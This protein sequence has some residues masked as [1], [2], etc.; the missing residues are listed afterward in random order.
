[1]IRLA[2]VGTGGMAQNHARAFSAIKGVTLA[3]CCDIDTQK[4]TSFAGSWNIP[5]VYT[6]YEDM[7]ESEKL[8]A[9]SN[10]AVD[11]MHAP[12]S[13]AAVGR[14]IPVLCE[15]PL[16]TNLADARRMRDAATRR[17]VVTHVNF[18]YRDAPCAQAAA[19]FIRGGGIGRVIH[20]EAS[21]LQSWL[22]QDTWGDWRTT[23]AFTWRL[24]K[25]HGSAGV[26]GDTG[27]HIYDMTALLCGDISE[28]FCRME[29]FDKG[30]KGGR[31]GPYVLDANDS[32]VSTIR[33]AGGG[34]GT[35]HA[36]RW[37]TGHLNSLRVRAYG[38]EGAVEVDLDR[39]RDSYRVCRGKT[40]VRKM[41]WT[42]VRCRR[43]PTQYERF[44]KAIRAGTS[45]VCDFGNGARVQACLEASA[46][47][48]REKR[49]MTVS[50]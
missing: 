46:D 23:P 26:L 47:S 35:V 27:C 44:I 24:S 15:K 18:T 5:R 6:D 39:S 34:I 11:I 45:D 17:K 13:L 32:F 22:V 30:V 50:A 49:P 31:L 21:Y 33:L 48:A 19:A 10:V 36:T 9:L 25:K 43:T 40:H 16:A 4:A 3:A 8:D 7:L 29:T 41:Q 14:G 12:I 42:E 28:I 37:A 38:D 20:V 1:M 2:I